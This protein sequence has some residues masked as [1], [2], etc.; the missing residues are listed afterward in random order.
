MSSSFEPDTIQLIDTHFK[1]QEQVI[2]VYAFETPTGLAL[3]DCGPYTVYE[4]VKKGLH[5]LGYAISDVRHL[6][7]TH[8]HLDHSGGAWK[9]AQ[10]SDA[11]IYVHPKGAPHLADPTKLI[12]SATRIYGDM[13]EPLWGQIEPVP[14][15]RIVA[16]ADREKLNFGDPFHIEVIE[17]LGHASHHQVYRLD[18]HIFTGDIAGVRL[19]NGPALPP[20]P[21]PDIHVESWL[22]S[23]RLLKSLNP[24]RIYLTH[25]GSANHPNAILEQVEERLV[26]W[27]GW[28][29][30]RMQTGENEEAI[31]PQFETKVL[32][33]L[34]A[35]GLTQEWVDAYY[36]SDPPFMSVLGL[37]RYWRK[38]HGIH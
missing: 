31:V 15:D 33:E 17:T 24:E 5:K 28:I 21:P 4:N 12:A 11:K 16:T 34:T 3:V 7:L 6:L 2:A 1:N 37:C 25:F 19:K 35:Y 32:E 14:A 8:I 22:A 29:K 13:M 27:A 18:R 10:E 38:F 23:L 20:C 9:I 30:A 36:S 26:N